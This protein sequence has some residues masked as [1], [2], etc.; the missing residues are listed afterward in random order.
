MET[1][2]YGQFVVRIEHQTGSVCLFV[3]GQ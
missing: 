1:D 3:F 2:V